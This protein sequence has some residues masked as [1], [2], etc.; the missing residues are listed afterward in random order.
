V[1]ELA[2]FCEAAMKLVA[3]PPTPEGEI[4]ALAKYL[5]DRKN[6]RVGLLLSDRCE[7]RRLDGDVMRVNVTSTAVFLRVKQKEVMV[8]LAEVVGLVI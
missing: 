1:H 3:D 4:H 6:K 8:P 7:H 2:G 5:R